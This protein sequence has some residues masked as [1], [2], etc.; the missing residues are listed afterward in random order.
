MQADNKKPIAYTFDASDFIL[1][2]E[3][4]GYDIDAYIG[5]KTE[6]TIP[7]TIDGVRVAH[8]NSLAFSSRN[9][10]FDKEHQAFLRENF[11]HVFIPESVRVER[12]AFA[13]CLKLQIEKEEY[14]S[15]EKWLYYAPDCPSPFTPIV[16]E[17]EKGIYRTPDTNKILW[18]EFVVSGEYHT[19]GAGALMSRNNHVVYVCEGVK[20]IEA[21]AFTFLDTM[22][23][24]Y[25]PSTL[26]YLSPNA[27]IEC[28]ALPPE[29]IP[30]K[31]RTPPQKQY[32]ATL[33][34]HCEEWEEGSSY[35]IKNDQTIKLDGKRLGYRISST[36]YR[37]L[38]L[39]EDHAIV[40]LSNVDMPVTI[41][42]STPATFTFGVRSN[43]A[44]IEGS[45]YYE[46]DDNYEYTFTLS[47]IEPIQ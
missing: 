22:H 26:E 8:I 2:K 27:F 31:F 15:Q 18:N 28:D 38:E 24:V 39:T 45:R 32:T 25:L 4:Y 7:E 35:R 42:V 34:I 10:R 46:C 1:I 19:I 13:G 23:T 41:P 33:D 43:G 3:S 6:V 29:M 21:G 16:R 9:P 17:G 14:W 37:L 11:T 12:L 36:E 20:R 30:E 5:N 40:F 47:H 44:I